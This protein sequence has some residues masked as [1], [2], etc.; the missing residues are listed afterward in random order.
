MKPSAN[1][2]F[3]AADSVCRVGV[4]I[5]ERHRGIE[6]DGVMPSLA[7]RLPPQAFKAWQL[8]RSSPG[9]AMV[10]NRSNV[11]RVQIQPL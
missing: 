3:T 8:S 6:L 11:A 5:G 10:P 7:D 9:T 4:P 2:A 1:E